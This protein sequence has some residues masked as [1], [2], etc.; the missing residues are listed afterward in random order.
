MRRESAS[1][2]AVVITLVVAGCA[3]NPPMPPSVPLRGQT[4]ETMQRDRADC[5]QVA[6]TDPSITAATTKGGGSASPWMVGG[7][8]T[9]TGRLIARQRAASF[10][11]CMESRG[12]TVEREP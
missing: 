1:V 4:A 6:L 10:G 5:E 11:L 3:A 7:P 8:D 9:A 12:Y 2:L